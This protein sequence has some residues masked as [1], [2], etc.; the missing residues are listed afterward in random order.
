M[1]IVKYVAELIQFH[2][3]VG[4]DGFGTIYKK[5]SPGRYD[6]VS[7]TFL[8]PGSTTAFKQEVTESNLLINELIAKENISPA[9]AADAVSRFALQLIQQLNEYGHADFSPIGR[10][11]K[12]NG[13]ILLE[14]ST[15]FNPG[16]EFFG[17]PKI[18]EPEAPVTVIPATPVIPVTIPVSAV[19][20]EDSSKEAEIIQE[21]M[22]EEENPG[23]ETNEEIL[24]E[25]RRPIIENRINYTIKE[26]KPA[27]SGSLLTKVA[28]VLLAILLLSVAAYYLYPRFSTS[29]TEEPTVPAAA[30]QQL[31]IDSLAR[32]AREQAIL[33]SATAA[34]T[35]VNASGKMEKAPAVDSV[36]AVVPVVKAPAETAVTYEVI[37]AS[38]LNEKEASWFIETMKKSG[39]KAKVV[40]NAPGKRLKMSIA[41]LKDENTAK[42][43]RDRLGEK[44]KIKG[45]YIY[46][47]KPQ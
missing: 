40:H 39:I 41:T 31:R 22:L 36:K 28:V 6:S 46:K 18:T 15:D 32:V 3:E 30:T 21:N 16:K 34:D 25:I 9:V 17:L 24:T 8:P 14:Q 10:L 45:L 19:V 4:I 12:A 23:K 29:F 13:I 7:R 26:E 5:K 47:N 27:E 43:E 2:K 20:E 37:G 35:L 42:A 33:D 38:V 1:E 44:L 11:R